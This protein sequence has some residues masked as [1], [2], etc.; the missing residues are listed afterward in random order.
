MFLIG[1][2]FKGKLYLSETDEL[3]NAVNAKLIYEKRKYI[4][5]FVKLALIENY[6]CL[7]LFH[8]E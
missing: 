8:Y 2:L 3:G 5:L 6:F 1:N 4:I 7:I